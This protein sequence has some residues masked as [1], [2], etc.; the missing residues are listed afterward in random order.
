MKV[1]VYNLKTDLDDTI[2][3]LKKI[4]SKKIGVSERDFNFL[5]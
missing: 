5:K 4:T 3:D 2:Y 1:I